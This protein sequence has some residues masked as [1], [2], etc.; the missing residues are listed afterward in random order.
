MV[1]S[2]WQG[3]RE[4]FTINYYYMRFFNMDALRVR[5]Y[6]C[7]ALRTYILLTY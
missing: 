3:T 7:T 1:L 2:S 5:T 6:E 4:L